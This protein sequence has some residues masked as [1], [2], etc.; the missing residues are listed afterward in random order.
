MMSDNSDQ[1]TLSSPSLLSS[2]SSSNITTNNVTDT[3]LY[4]PPKDCLV[5]SFSALSL[6]WES[7]EDLVSYETLQSYQG[8]VDAYLLTLLVFLSVP[9]NTVNMIVFWKHGIKERINLCLF[10]LSFADLIIV[11]AHF[12]WKVSCVCGTSNV[13]ASHSSSPPSTTSPPLS[14]FSRPLHLSPL[15]PPLLLLLL[16]P[17]LVFILFF[18]C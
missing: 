16:L 13:T 6:P 15:P 11:L 5:F 7:A 9:S 4:T 14:S 8:V 12:V 2:P 18:R 1:N 3:V 17:L 10:F